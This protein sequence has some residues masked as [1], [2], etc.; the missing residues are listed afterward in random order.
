MQHFRA[1]KQKSGVTYYYFDAGGIPRKEIPLGSDYQLA[2]R[3]WSELV[4]DTRL[5]VPVTTFID[6]IERYEIEELVKLA[7]STQATYRSDLKHLREFFGLPT[8]APLDL[9]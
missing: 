9:I 7:K 3:K 6:L 4:A 5:P 1:R 2:V 8:P